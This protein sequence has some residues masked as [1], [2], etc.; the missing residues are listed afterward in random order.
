MAKD[1][2]FRHDKQ[3]QLNARHVTLRHIN[4]EEQDDEI[5]QFL[6]H[7]VEDATREEKEDER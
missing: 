7:S 2:E 1:K 6:H 4:E 3:K 5:R